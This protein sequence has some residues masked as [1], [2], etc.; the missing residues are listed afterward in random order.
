[1]EK[2]KEKEA[3]FHNKVRGKELEGDK[4][5]YKHLTSNRKFY[6]I[7]R[8]S[9]NFFN[10][11]LIQNCLGK[12][13][14]DYCCGD[15]GTT[16]FLAEH[17]AEAIG[18][19]ISTVSI[20]NAKEKT[21]NK[22]L[23]EKA[24]FFV[25]DAENLKFS[26]DYFD[27]I[28]CAGVLHHLDIKKA[29]QEL[30]RVLKPGG[31]IICGEPLVYNPVFQLYRKL[32]PHLRTPWETEHI[33]SRKDIQLAEN[34]F[35]D[36]E[37]RFFHLATLLAVPFRNIPFIFNPFLSLLEFIDSILL[38]LPLL[39]WWAWQIVFILSESKK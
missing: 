12:K 14:L 31:K 9:Q 18:I 10:N 20:Q 21:Q 24:S 33:L 29:Y 17:G 22:G 11:Y 26:N 23:G 5:G 35:G 6:A 16:I 13:S 34:Y 36:I 32:T 15:G 4:Q 3:K 25:M 37:T 28:I 30:A 1:M 27:L 8:K 39:R 7:V 19:D 38:R 2:R